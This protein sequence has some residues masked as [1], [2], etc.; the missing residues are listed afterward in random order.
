MRVY[1][2]RFNP[3]KFH[4]IISSQLNHS[5]FSHVLNDRLQ[6][7]GISS[8]V[9]NSTSKSLPNFVVEKSKLNT[10]TYLRNITIE[11]VDTA[12]TPLGNYMIKL[13][14]QG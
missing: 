13:L 11:G 14:M 5:N 9:M 4:L 3:K 12:S 6:T 10:H 2:I 8:D 7:L 1:N